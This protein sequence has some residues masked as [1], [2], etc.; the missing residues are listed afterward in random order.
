MDL[1]PGEHEQK[2][3]LNGLAAI[4]EA[5]GF[6][7]FV[8][9]PLLEPDPRFFPE[10]WEPSAR[11][12][13]ALALRL[14]RHA[15]LENEDAS[16]TLFGESLPRGTHRGAL[17]WFAGMQGATC[18]FGVHRNQLREHDAIVGTLCHEAAH[19]YRTSTGLAEAYDRLD[20]ENTDLTTIY[21]GFGILSTNN[22]YRFRK[23]STV[24][25]RY[26]GIEYSTAQAG[27]LS[28]QAMA[29]ALAAQVTSRGVSASEAK[30]IERLLEGHQ[31][32]FFHAA[33]LQFEK[34]VRGL[35]FRLGLPP[36][37]TWPEPKPVTFAQIPDDAIFVPDARAAALLDTPTNEG[38]NVFCVRQTHAARYA[39]GG[40]IVG[41][42]AGSV[43][44]MV[45]GL[46]PPAVVLG[47]AVLGALAL[48]SWGRF[49]FTE[50]CSDPEC[51]ASLPANADSCLRCHGRVRGTIRDPGE[52]LT[53]EEA[54][55]RESRRIA[56]APESARARKSTGEVV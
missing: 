41:A 20:E 45:L 56:G 39:L 48:G 31:Q 28:P 12:V 43:A 33:R 27:Y 6:E 29:F 52:R 53:A 21:L 9:A 35:R 13:R 40:A 44:S 3:L 14:L 30:R 54:L 26:P 37:E 36:V 55:D 42:L 7:T 1:L 11:G 2:A 8:L 49:R 10:P 50:T 5:R 38:R 47:G 24:G 18:L 15:G 34:D 16:V 22:A 23:R 46:A 51:G 32:A 17:A 4:I 25:V 19:A